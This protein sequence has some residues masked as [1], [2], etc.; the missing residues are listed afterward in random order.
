MRNTGADK[1]I[2]IEELV[3]PNTL[4]VVSARLSNIACTVYC[5][6]HVAPAKPTSPPPPLL[7][8]L[9][10]QPHITATLAPLD[11]TAPHPHLTRHCLDH[12]LKTG[13]AQSHAHFPVLTGLTPHL[14]TLD[15]AWTGAGPARGRTCRRTFKTDAAA[16][17][18]PAWAVRGALTAG[19]AALRRVEFWGAERAEMEV[20]PY[21]DEEGWAEVR[22]GRSGV[23]GA[24]VEEVSDVTGEGGR[25]AGAGGEELL[26]GLER[27]VV[28]LVHPA[29]VEQA[30][31]YRKKGVEV[32][33]GELGEALRC[34]LNGEVNTTLRELAVTLDFVVPRFGSAGVRGGEIGSDGAKFG[35]SGRLGSLRGFEGLRRLH[36]SWVVL[37]GWS[38]RSLQKEVRTTRGYLGRVLPRYLRW[39]IITDEMG[40]WLRWE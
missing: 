22:G 28:E 40:T 11:P 14:R 8:H 36:V 17:A 38:L 23:E 31:T 39:L 21:G 30:G 4:V 19:H 1:V 29:T 24:G 33:L 34:L 32:A 37:A 25:G 3:S 7:T 2:V 18:L 10:R 26:S 16:A 13:S 5:H 35:V 20:R 15:L 9:H 27:L 6:A 12:G